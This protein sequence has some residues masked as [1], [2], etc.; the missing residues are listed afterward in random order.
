MVP[1]LLS[2]SFGLG[3][4]LL[5]EGLTNPGAEDEPNRPPAER[6]RVVREFLVRAGLQ[7]VTPRDFA[8]FALAAGLFTSLAAQ[9]LLGWPLVSGLVGL[10]GMVAPVAYYVRR[11]DRRRAAIQAGLV[12][13][14]S[15]LRDGI[16]SGLAVS[17]GLAALGRTGP[18]VL[19]PEFARLV[20]ESRLNGLEAAL[21]GMQDRLA[22]PLFDTAASA[23]R[24]NERLGGRNVSQVLDRL[25]QATRNQQR[26][27]NELRASQ[28]HTILSAQIVA[29]VPLVVLVIIRGMNPTYLA[30]FNTV[31][32]QMLLAAT[33][34]SVALGYLAMLWMARL[35]GEPRVL[36]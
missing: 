33:V 4:W 14:M 8:L 20:R 25:A 7:E 10:L 22:D 29:L 6:F 1:L 16:R 30:V 23:L 15:Q 3:V 27:L 24:L 13:A 36:R 35:P 17:E 5:Y 28:A 32:G 31:T 19:R 34:L 18:Q 26:V 21:G 11:H 12:E 2:I 9:L